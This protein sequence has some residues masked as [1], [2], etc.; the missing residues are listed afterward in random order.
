[1]TSAF[2]S[3]VPLCHTLTIKITLEFGLKTHCL[4]G[5]CKAPSYNSPIKRLL[6][7]TGLQNILFDKCRLVM[8]N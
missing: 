7:K 8:L 2:T 4:I 1:M 6:S 3:V 5:C